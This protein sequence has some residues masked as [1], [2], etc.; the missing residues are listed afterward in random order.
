MSE[1]GARYLPDDEIMHPY[2]SRRSREGHYDSLLEVIR[3]DLEYFMAVGSV[4]LHA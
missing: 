4:I 1:E 2:V 3:F